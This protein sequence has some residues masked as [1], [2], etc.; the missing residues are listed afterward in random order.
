LQ[1][2]IA[3]QKAVTTNERSS[4]IRKTAK[5]VNQ[6]P[7]IVCA[8]GPEGCDLGPRHT[9]RIGDDRVVQLPGLGNYR[10]IAVAG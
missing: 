7:I 3:R 10:N 4:A 9:D 2:L 1:L 8:N 6:V 5:Y